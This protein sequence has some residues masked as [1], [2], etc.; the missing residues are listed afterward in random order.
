MS[1][2]SKITFPR[3]DLSSFELNIGNFIY[4]V[5][6]MHSLKTVSDSSDTEIANDASHRFSF[7]TPY[8]FGFD[9]SPSAANYH[10]SRVRRRVS[11]KANISNSPA[12]EI[13]ANP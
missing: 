1:F 6:G 9:K 5:D 3:R 11:K 2:S 8:A 10:G 13:P 7:T 12:L 4:F